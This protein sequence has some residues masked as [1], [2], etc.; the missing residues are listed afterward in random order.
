[1]MD[2]SAFLSS[3]DQ[4]QQLLRNEKTGGVRLVSPEARMA[5]DRELIPQIEELVTDESVLDALL[6]DISNQIKESFSTKNITYN[7][8]IKYKSID[9]SDS[10][11]AEDVL[12]AFS[13]WVEKTRSHITQS[14]LLLGEI[15]PEPAP[16][17]PPAPEPAI[18]HPIPVSVPVPV[19]V[20]VP[21]PAPAPAP[22][23]A[24]APAPAPAETKEKDTA[25]YSP[26]KDSP[27]TPS[28]VQN[29]T[30]PSTQVNI[31]VIPK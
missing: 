7:R 30:G 4:L 11:Y 17:A 10:Q 13:D 14:D 8:L 15:E 18:P 31:Q 22:T 25:K 20:P 27:S 12:Q 16:P 5:L 24:P 26:L 2:L 3:N 1:M 9:Q 29:S 6:D 19:P 28:N 23:P 21:A